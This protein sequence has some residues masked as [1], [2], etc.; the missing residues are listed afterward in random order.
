VS[1]PLA[2][3]STQTIQWYP[4]HMA[5]AM[6]RL[7]EDLQIVDVVIEAIDARVP[8]SGGN[9]ALAKLAA[10][11]PRAGRPARDDRL[12][13]AFSRRRAPGAGRQHEGAR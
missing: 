12:A 2:S 13:R 8:L 3:A 9:P 10:C 6:R 4:G 5:R 7:A 11:G 1:D